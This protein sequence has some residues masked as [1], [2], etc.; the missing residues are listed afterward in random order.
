MENITLS[1]KNLTLVLLLLF[2]AAVGFAQSQT[3]NTSGTFTAP[4]GVTVI[5]VEAWGGGGKGGSRSTTGV[6]GGGGGGGYTRKT[7]TVVPG[8]SYTV[9][10][11]TGGVTSGVAGGDTYFI[12][13]TTVLAKGGSS[14]A[15]NSTTGANGGV[16]TIYGDVS[17]AGGRG[18]NGVTSSYGGGGGSSAG[19]ASNGGIAIAQNGGSAT[20][21]GNGGDGRTTNNDG[22]AGTAPGGGGG[23]SLRTSATRLGGNGGNGRLYISWIPEINVQGN[24]V[25]IT[26]GDVS[27]SLTDASDFGTMY[28]GTPNTQTFTVENLG[29]STLA[30]GAISFSGL[31]ASEFAVTTAPASSVAPYSST[32]FVVTFTPAAV[33]TKSATISIANNDA[34]ENP[35]I[36]ALGANVI[37]P[38]INVKGNTI[39]IVNGDASP[40]TADW[41]SFGTTDVASGTLTR[42][43]TIENSGTSS[44]TISGISFSGTNSGDFSVTTGPAATVTAGSTT[45]FVVTFNPSA[46][47]L[48]TATISIA[49]NDSNE[50]P[51]TFALGGN[52]TDP[53][54]NVSGNST[55]ILDGDITPSIAD[56]TDF[57]LSSVSTGSISRTFTIENKSSA[58][59]ALNVIGAINISGVNATDFT[60]TTVP[61]SSVAI[62][63]STTFIVIFNPSASGTRSAT[64]TIT[65]NDSNES[66]YTFNVQGTGTD[67]E[68]NVQGLASNNI[69][70]GDIT[71]SAA[72]GTI[73]GSIDIASGTILRTFTIQNTGN[74]TLNITGVSI[75]GLSAADYSVTSA[76]A[77]TVAAA[78]NTTF[79]VTFNPTTVGLKNATIVID[80]N[81]A[82]EATYDFAIQGTATDPEINIQGNG[83]S[84]ADGDS[85][86]SATDWTT[87]G[88]TDI[89]SGS[90][91]RTFTIQNLITGTGVLTIGAIT[92]SGASAADFS[93]TTAPSPSVT[94]NTATTFVVTFN[95]SAIGTRTATMSIVNC[96]SDENPYDFAISGIGADPEMTIYNNG[97]EIFTG[98]TT[99]NP[100]N[101]NFGTTDIAAGTIARTFSVLNLGTATI[102]LNL[103]AI[104]FSGANA[105]DFTVTTAPGLTT[106]PIAASTTFVV[107]FN[108]SAVGVRNATMTIANNDS[109]ENPYTFALSGNGGDPEI[110]IQ[111]NGVS[112]VDGDTTPATSDWTDYG[113]TEITAGTS[114]RTYTIYNPS[115]AS[116]ALTIGAITFS[117]TNPGDFSVTTAPAAS[118]AVGGSSSFTVTFNPSA[119]GTRSA[120]LNMVNNDGN[121]NPY[122]F[123]IQ[124]TGTNPEINLIGN[125]ISIV[126]GDTTPSVSDNTDFGTVSIDAGSTLVTY[127]IQNT[128]TGNMNIG[129]VLISGAN[130]SDF[131]ITSYPTPTIAGGGSTTL[132]ISFSPA[133]LG[134]KTATI[135]IIND[136]ANENPYDFSITGFGVRTYT[137]TDGDNI[138]DNIDIDDDNDGILDVT[139]E[140]ECRASVVSG[141]ITHTFLNETFGAGTTKGLININIPNASCGYCYE[142]GVAGPNTTACPSQSSWI[143][144]DGEYVVTYKIAGTTSGDPENIHGDLAWNGLL[145]HTVG[146]TNGRMAVFNASYTPGTFYETA[147][148]GIIPNAPITYSFYVLNIMSVSNYVGSILPNIT[149]EF[150]DTTTGAVLS[151]YNTGN[152]G[153]CNGGTGANGCA[154]S[155]WQY[156]TTTVNLG[157][158][159][160]FTI[161]FKNNST[162]GGGNDLAIDDILLTQQY[163]DR[164]GDGIANLYDLDSDNDGIPDIEEG[165]YK[166]LSSG[167]STMDRTL[168]GWSDANGNGMIDSIDA[169]IAG[170]TYAIADTDGD[171]TKDFQDLDSDNDAMFDV[172][173]SGLF[174]G[175]GDINGDGFGDGL[176]TDKDGILDLF[177]TS[178][179]F[180]TA[181][182]VFA[183]DTNNDGVA[184]YLDIDA[185]TDGVKDILT[186][187]Y[188][189]YDANL[190]GKID[191]TADADRDGI[192]DSFDTKTTA[193]GSPR[194]LNRKLFLDFDGRNDYGEAPQMLSGLGKS[195]IMGW[196]KLSS[197]YTATGFVIGQDNFNLK[198]DTS[199]GTKLTATANGV[200]LTYGTALSVNRWYHIAAVYDGANTTAKL[201]IFINGQEEA[202]SNAGALSESLAASS[203]KFT[204]GKNA[205]S[206]AQYFKGS[207]EEVRVFNTAL[208]TDQLQKMVYQEIKQ[209]GTAIRGEIVPKDIESSLWAN[210]LAY[211]RM[212]AYKDDVIDNYT[213][214]T[215]DAG[216]NA[217]FAKIYN[218][219]VITYQLAPMP[220]VTTLSTTLDAAVSQNNFVYGND[221][222]TYNWSILQMK[223]NIDLP[224]NI[225]NLGLFVDPSVTFNLT[226]DNMVKNTWYLMLNG[227]M[228][229]QGRSQLVQTGTSDLDPVSSGFI[230]RD[231]QGTTNKWN[232]NYW[233]SPVGAVNNTTNNNV[234]TVASGMKDG[235]N[236]ANPQSILW[237]TGLNSSATSP[238]TLSSYW[239]FKFQNVTN[240]YANWAT[241]GPN[242]NLGTGQG[243][244]MKGS[245]AATPTQNYVFVG[246]PNTGVVAI[247]I[248]G[249]N[250]NLCGNPYASAIDAD[251]FITDNLAATTGVLYFWEHFSTNIT[252]VL[253]DYQGGYA[254]RTLV[255]GTTPVSPSGV[256]NLGTSTKRPGRYIPVGQGFFV[257]ATATGGDIKFNND[258]RA[259]VKENNVD[260]NTVFRNNGLAASPDSSIF[261][262]NEDATT[263]DTYARVRVGFNSINNYHREVLIGFMDE[264]A[265]PAI[266]PGYDAKHI[267]NQPNDMYFMTLGEK[268]NIQGDG[269]FNTANVY[270]IGVKSAGAGAMSFTLDE[271][272]NFPASQPVYIYDN[273]TQQYHNIR[274]EKFDF[275]LDAATTVNDRFSLRF[276]TGTSLSTGEV[277]L[278][279]GIVAAYANAN[280]TLTIKNNVADVTIETVS[281]YNLLGQSIATWDV[282]NQ[283]QQNIQIPVKNLSTGTYIVKM[284]TTKGDVSKKIIIK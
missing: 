54:I 284:K 212:D 99:T 240:A 166:G 256:S 177:D 253:A 283:E 118:V 247:P 223:H 49:N 6:G 71:P 148:T 170:G 38:E 70:D 138:T 260:S 72:D 257:T 234:F 4:A 242:G 133:T 78:G 130:A 63:G 221:L 68:I 132:V 131:I 224:F 74:E 279:N 169:A 34:D 163:C 243:F 9:V 26:N 136:D 202:A 32:T 127:T 119:T 149:V 88:T 249:G 282:E 43:F 55:D 128:G 209:N 73:V 237:T 276:T 66:P 69:G 259:F 16:A 225:T 272:E 233:G 263:E 203:A 25:D 199:S 208:T 172:D 115:S 164:E 207:I 250:L 39:S 109:D 134:I 20:G 101:T 105:G 167:K 10:V 75:S 262:N 29:T 232:Y 44:L 151:T 21:G 216:I 248:A 65:S 178:V 186:T 146:D 179:A 159:T 90:I 238:I 1:K 18:A 61:A 107:T 198:V 180:G 59:M 27:P 264:H 64:V 57:G 157:T 265:G 5:T 41:T 33:G 24:S 201:K 124:G 30:L 51:Y 269:Y 191:G 213:T 197:P 100:L 37:N 215:I 281:L 183:T 94:N 154:Y 42:T 122:N 93:V 19:P 116:M 219:K 126:D 112:I 15:N 200:T 114:T 211:Y 189:S 184:N 14:A 83:V 113:S 56:F 174:N 165:G 46:T 162:G 171:G 89:A 161:R 48:R 123:T 87:F 227:K 82:D 246:K 258:Q 79:V 142:D 80:S 141:Y 229:L 104:S 210:V 226:N 76:P 67:P 22:F 23:G 47:G 110:D 254:T 176:D 3:F 196:I 58:T 152:I 102:A 121:E 8:N 97:G 192:L 193:Y 11:G 60:V 40:A 230:E 45:T 158:V 28:P 135:T 175:D 125:L 150:L 85:S 187:L 17:F 84:I 261:N 270:P 252:H 222:F 273:V 181:V 220:F 173:E 120:V 214:G 7:I 129:S 268:L 236:P 62:G 195:T 218:H 111:G 153:R 31:S 278:A 185:N 275:T 160:N 117:G 267:D 239:I 251:K 156:Y 241:V 2:T 36:F 52:A 145:D 188:G 77:S 86:P 155:E 231:Q 168:S 277:T 103:G 143:L 255:G 266:D 206:A 280:S 235:T 244:T 217:S 190:D 194:D 147:I 35:Y 182:R 13:N 98:T 245:N 81:D 96:D 95:P 137:D 140:L 108:P 106:I 228:D 91:T 144:D 12:N 53:E 50:N 274:E 139:E 271:L 204:F 92:F 205:T